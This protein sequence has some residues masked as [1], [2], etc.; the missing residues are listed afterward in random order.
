MKFP[1]DGCAFSYHLVSTLLIAICLSQR[2]SR[3]NN[4]NLRLADKTGRLSFVALFNLCE[5]QQK[6]AMG[7]ED[8]RPDMINRDPNG[9]N[10]NLVVCHYIIMKNNSR[11]KNCVSQKEQSH[12]CYLNSKSLII[13]YGF[14]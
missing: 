10:T 2:G 6:N 1:S 13:F 4:S 8:G 11:Q 9:L 12:V 5:N 7:E 3:P 14:D